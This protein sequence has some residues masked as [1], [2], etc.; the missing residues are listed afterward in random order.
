MQE[1]EHREQGGDQR[2]Q[3]R[4]TQRPEPVTMYL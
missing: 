4:A 3:E 1:R 2:S